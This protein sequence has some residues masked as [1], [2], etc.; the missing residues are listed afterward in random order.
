MAE[1]VWKLHTTVAALCERDG[2]FLL[3][4]EL[5]D[6]CIVYNLPTYPLDVISQEFA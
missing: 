3:V 2:K 4:K 6:G 1:T 5:V